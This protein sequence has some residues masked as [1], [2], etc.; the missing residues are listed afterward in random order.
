[1]PTPRISWRF[2]KLE[3]SIVLFPL[4]PT[5]V[6]LKVFWHSQ[7]QQRHTMKSKVI[8]LGEVP[9]LFFF[10]RQVFI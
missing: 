9:G 10:C 3:A 8:R 2:A 4:A 7:V 6:V 5:D 1:M